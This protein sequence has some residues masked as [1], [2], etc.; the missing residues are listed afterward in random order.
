[1]GAQPQCP[2][3]PDRPRSPLACGG[4]ASTGAA[5]RSRVDLILQSHSQAFL[6]FGRHPIADA[7]LREHQPRRG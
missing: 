6:V 7:R 2:Y 4:F 1:M 3:R 5:P